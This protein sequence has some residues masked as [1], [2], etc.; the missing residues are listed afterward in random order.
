MAASHFNHLLRKHVAEA[1]AITDL[2]P[3]LSEIITLEEMQHILHDRIQTLESDAQR[4]IC[5]N[6]LPIQAMLP[7]DLIQHIV[8]FTD[9]SSDQ[10]INLEAQEL[11][12]WK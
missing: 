6:S 4:R 2:I 10:Y 8:S 7:I 9:S 5:C 12:P 11:N 1:T 3:L